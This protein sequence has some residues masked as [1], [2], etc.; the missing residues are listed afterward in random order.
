MTEP[1]TPGP[2]ASRKLSEAKIR[3]EARMSDAELLASMTQDRGMFDDEEDDTLPCGCS[4]GSCYCDSL[5]W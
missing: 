1:T 5:R 3:R 4:S 2:L